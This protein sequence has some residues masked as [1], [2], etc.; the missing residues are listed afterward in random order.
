[1]LIQLFVTVALFLT[2]F[3]APLLAV[4]QETTT[5]FAAA[6]LK[7][8]LDDIDATFTK[9]TGIKVTASYEAMIFDK[10]GFSFLVKPVS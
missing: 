8:T 3:V 4:A 6:S 1:M 7:N 5:V 10:Y 9:A 2:F